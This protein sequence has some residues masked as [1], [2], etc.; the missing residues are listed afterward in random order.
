MDVEISVQVHSITSAAWSAVLPPEP[1]IGPGV[2]IIFQRDAIFFMKPID[3][4]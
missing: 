1:S 2:L 4:F 3:H